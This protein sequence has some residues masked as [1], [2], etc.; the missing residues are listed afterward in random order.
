MDL[1]C[2]A[3]FVMLYYDPMCL[4]AWETTWIVYL[5]ALS[6]PTP[7]GLIRVVVAAITDRLP[8][9]GTTISTHAAGPAPSSGRAAAAGVRKLRH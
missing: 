1:V 6:T 4:V 3:C 2:R 9:S 8:S 7:L 5:L